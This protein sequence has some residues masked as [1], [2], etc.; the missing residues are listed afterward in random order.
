MGLYGSPYDYVIH[1]AL[2]ATLCDR[3]TLLITSFQ[4]P[5]G[6]TQ[7]VFIVYYIVVVD[8]VHMLSLYTTNQKEYLQVAIRVVRPSCKFQ[9]RQLEGSEAMFSTS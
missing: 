7:M 8:K 2:I 9:L 1:I 6:H 4:L 5:L 3:H